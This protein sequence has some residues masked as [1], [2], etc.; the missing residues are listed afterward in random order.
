[1][2]EKAGES[3]ETALSV[4]VE[5]LNLSSVS[6]SDLSDTE[7]ACVCCHKIKDDIKK[8]RTRVLS[9]VVI[10]GP[11][12]YLRTYMCIYVHMCILYVC[13]FIFTHTVCTCVVHACLF[14]CS[15]TDV[16]S[17]VHTVC[18]CVHNIPHVYHTM[19]LHTYLSTMTCLPLLDHVFRIS[20][21]SSQGIA[22][23]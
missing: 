16:H 5:K 21:W 7:Q 15:T 11:S 13:T 14:T 3:T 6:K 19:H 23:P 17:Y 10:I 22:S 18:T 8:V 2:Y 4:L 20:L 12:L 9:L 1:M